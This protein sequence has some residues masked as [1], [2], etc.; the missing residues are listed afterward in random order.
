MRQILLTGGA[1]GL[2][3]AAAEYL[4]ERGC[5]V[6]ACDIR[7]A[8]PKDNIIL[9]MMDVRDEASVAAAYEQVAART[10]RL[11]AVIHLAG[12]YMMDS[13]VEISEERLS[14]I[15]DV[16][17]M[18]VYRVNKAFLPLVRQGGGRIVITTSELAGQKALP[19]TGIYALT[20][21]ALGCYAD[22]LRLELK[23]LGVPVIEL[24]PGA[25]KTQLTVEP[26]LE[27]DKL[28]KSTRL[29]GEGLRRIKPLMDSRIG[30]EREPVMLAALIYRI[31]TTRKPRLRYSPNASMALRLYSALPRRVQAFAIRRLLG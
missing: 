31:V 2:G 28:Q 6:F 9:V 14:R 10:D 17:L 21:T 29:Y 13:F 24:R 11:D 22:S 23:L 26:S 30:K 27:L 5:R 19:F 1:G 3:R 18:G 7:E 15:L 20:K 8:E 16:N 25:F 4:A 12:L